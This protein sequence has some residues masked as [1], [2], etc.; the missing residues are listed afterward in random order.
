MKTKNNIKNSGILLLM[1]AIFAACSMPHHLLYTTIDV[2][3]PASM[4]FPENINNLLVVNNCVQQPET[5]GHTLSLLNDQPKPISVNT[6]SLPMFLLSALNE[7]IEDK[8]FFTDN[9]LIVN[10]IN[11]RD[12]FAK[13]SPIL[14]AQVKNLME[15]TGTDAILSLNKLELNDLLSEGY[16]VYTNEYVL[17]LDA[18]YNSYWTLQFTDNQQNTQTFIFQDTVYWESSSYDRRQ[19]INNFP[20]RY[21]ALVDG[22]LYVGQKMI[23]RLVPYWE[24]NDRYIFEINNPIVQQGM[25]SVTIRDWTGAISLWQKAVEQ[26]EKPKEKALIQHNIAVAQEISGDLSGALNIISQAIVNFGLGGNKKDLNTMLDL[27]DQLLERIKQQILLKEQ[28]GE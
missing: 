20:D 10:S 8:G 26:T 11:T 16:N 18:I 21:D 28:I 22:A 13:I 12:D 6:D 19:L 25:D 17:G 2:L 9:V 4:V 15:Q 3:R 14:P 1:S 7:E 27:R 23:N 5:Q 24:E